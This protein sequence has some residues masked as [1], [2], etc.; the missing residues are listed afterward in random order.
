MADET[1]YDSEMSQSVH[2]PGM[3]KVVNR[4]VDQDGNRIGPRAA[5]AAGK[6][7]PFSLKGDPAPK[8]SPKAPDPAPAADGSGIG[9]R[10]REATIMGQADKA[11][12]G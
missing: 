8:S 10:D 9:G 7:D 6:I 5:P 2:R 11:V 1:S 4:A 3:E 12:T